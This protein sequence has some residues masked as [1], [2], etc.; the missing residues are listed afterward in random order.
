MN[1]K[2]NRQEVDVGFLAK[3]LKANI[4]LILVVAVICAAGLGAFRHFNTVPTY[5]SSVSFFVNGLSM[6]TDGT[7]FVNPGNTSGATTLAE[8]FE[9]VI[10]SRSVVN[11]ALEVLPAGTKYDGITVDSAR[12]LMSAQLDVQILTVSVTHSDPDVAYELAHAMEKAAPRALDSY[13]GLS[14][15]ADNTISVVKVVE[16]A[17]KDT[18]PSGKNTVTFALI[19]FI[20]GAALVYVI[21]FLKAFFDRTI[22]TEEEVKD[23]FEMPVVGQIPSW[24]PD[25]KVVTKKDLKKAKADVLRDYTGRMLSPQTPFAVSEAFKLLRTN[26]CYTAN[27]GGSCA[28]YGIVSSN[29]GEGKSVVA[30]NTA[31][32]F[33]QMGKKVLLVDADLRAPVQRKIFNLDAK[34]PGLSDYLAGMENDVMISISGVENL[35]VIT[36]GRIPP[37]PAELLASPRMTQLVENAKQ[38]YDIVIIDLPPVC[39]VADA[40]VISGVVDHYLMVVRSTQSDIGMVSSALNML[41]GFDASVAGFVINDL[42]LKVSGYRKKSKYGKSYRYGYAYGYGATRVNRQ[43][44]SQS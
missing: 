1:N 12:K 3:I 23:H 11:K 34:A 18:T 39:E 37:N 26:M 43:D 44:D 38:N 17:V 24:N 9:I 22:Y 14:E 40:G 13:V 28:V 27:N 7:Q 41:A 2:E 31:I 5:T 16:N 36:S 20:L 30:A 10:T 8:S 4:V 33:A 42:N 35:S 32:S 15:D 19:G 6:N 21:A 29:A 25:G